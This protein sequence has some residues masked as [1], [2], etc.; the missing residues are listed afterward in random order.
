M[1]KAQLDSTINKVLG[2]SDRNKTVSIS[3]LHVNDPDV[4]AKFI[5]I[6]NKNYMVQ[7]LAAYGLN[8]SSKDDFAQIPKIIKL[9]ADVEG[10]LRGGDGK[11]VVFNL[12]E[13]LKSA[14]MTKEQIKQSGIIFVK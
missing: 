14:P 2:K 13:I 6:V 3:S 4:W 11:P 9:K 5:H 7:A 8:L 1:E 12:L 10:K